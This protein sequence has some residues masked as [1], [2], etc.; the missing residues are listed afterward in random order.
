MKKKYLLL[1]V[2]LMGFFFSSCRK[3]LKNTETPENYVGGSFSEVFQAFWD[4]M[5]SNYV[6]WSIET[7][8][9]DNIYKVYK[10]I[11]AGLDINKTSDIQKS[12]QYFRAM[13]AGLKDSHYNITFGSPIMDSFV[14]PST[15][16]KQNAGIL[17]NRYVFYYYDANYYLDS[18][19][20]VSGKDS[21]NV[22]G[23]DTTEAVS[24]TIGGNI[25]YL[26][27]NRFNLKNSYT[28]ADNG[29]KKVLQF[30]ID[31]LHNPPA[32]F[33]GVVI[34]VRG[35][36]GGDIND[37]NFLVGNMVGD[38]LIIGSTRNKNGNGRLDYTPWA[39][40]V[41]TPQPGAR[42]VTVPVV[43][44]TDIWSA[45]MSELTAMAIH[46]LPKGHTVG[47]KTWGA[48]GPLTGNEI[49]NGGQF[50]AANFMFVYTSSAMFRYKDGKIYEGEG[51]PP[52]FNVPFSENDFRTIGDTQLEKA[53]GLMR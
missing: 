20:I 32:D 8:D 5:N 26:G 51:F 6:F 48:N 25:L 9:W 33:K 35:N 44:L 14:S 47:E 53:L 16:R 45:S 39:D 50:T 29:V 27:F 49:L 43:A 11:F 13:T 17:R 38:K 23:V 28:S 30:F 31:Y 42:A 2:V 12:V 7:T 24:G 4:G 46:A 18:A 52:D 15:D 1:Y 3:D 41:V 34:D 22:S 37:L 19:S 36:G 40:A 21:I 10:P